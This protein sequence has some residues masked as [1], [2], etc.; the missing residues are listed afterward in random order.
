MRNKRCTRCGRKAQS[1]WNCCAMKN[2]PMPLCPGCDIQLNALAMEF[3][4]IKNRK[5][6]LYTYVLSKLV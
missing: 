4:K 5:E 6:L 2:K 3:A 1:T